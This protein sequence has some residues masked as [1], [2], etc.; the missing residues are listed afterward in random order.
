MFTRH[1]K[2]T[3]R[4]SRRN[5]PLAFKP[6]FY[7]I[8]TAPNEANLPIKAPVDVVVFKPNVPLYSSTGFFIVP[9]TSDTVL[10]FH[11]E[12]PPLRP[13]VTVLPTTL[14]SNVPKLFPGPTTLLTVA[15]TRPNPAG[16][17]IAKIPSEGMTWC[18]V[19][20]IV[21]LVVALG[22]LTPSVTVASEITPR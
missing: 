19:K 10:V 9:R 1:I 21:T 18:V 16:N 11:S 3:F 13:M 17:A 6:P 4:F 14:I 20:V 22:T 7:S 8:V 5:A 15:L 2:Q 12:P